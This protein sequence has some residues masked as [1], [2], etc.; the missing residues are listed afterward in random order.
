MWKGRKP[1]HVAVYAEQMEM[2]QMINFL[3]KTAIG[4]GIAGTLAVAA[5]TPSLAR[6]VVVDEGYSYAYPANDDI[7]VCYPSLAWQNR[8]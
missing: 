6:A 8:C 1:L 7:A 4:F 2:D 5:A 3:M